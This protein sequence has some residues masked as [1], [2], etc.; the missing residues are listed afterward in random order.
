LELQQ[1]TDPRLVVRSQPDRA[2]RGCH[3]C[4]QVAPSVGI[5]R[6]G[7]RGVRGRSA[8]R[9]PLSLHPLLELAAALYME[10]VEEG[11]SVMSERCRGVPARKFLEER[12]S[13]TREAFIGHADLVRAAP[14]EDLGAEL[15]AQ[16][17][18]RL[19]EGIARPGGIELGPEEGKK[20]IAPLGPAGSRDGEVHEQ[21]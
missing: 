13:V 6:H 7:P 4:G 20:P 2:L 10:G 17:A 15:L 16:K 12:D 5:L 21:R 18:E 1:V 19:I 9:R 11:A 14:D 3:G 8:E